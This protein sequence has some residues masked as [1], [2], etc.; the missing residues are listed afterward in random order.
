[1]IAVVG[2][3]MNMSETSKPIPIGP[4]PSVTIAKGPGFG[5]G[6]HQVRQ[7][8]TPNQKRDDDKQ[9]QYKGDKPKPGHGAQWSVPESQVNHGGRR[10]S[11]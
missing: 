1:M 11:A 3:G 2:M 8:F 10:Y 9:D 6:R 5:V 7:G 4:D